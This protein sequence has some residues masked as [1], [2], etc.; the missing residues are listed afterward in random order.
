ALVQK[1]KRKQ[2]HCSLHL[3]FKRTSILHT[4]FFHRT[5][6][7]VRPKDVD[8]DLFE[9][10]YVQC[11]LAELEKEVDEKINQFIAWAEKH[12][13]RKSQVCLSFFDEKNKHPGW[14][15]SKTERVYWEQW[16]I[17]LH[18]TSPKGQGKSRGSKAPAN[19]KGQ[20]LEE[21]SSRR[22][23]LSLLIQ[24]VLFQIINYANEKK[25]HIPPIS[26]RIFNHEILVPR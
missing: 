11:G 14:F 9:I 5:L 20:A 25:D 7:L 16:F 26:D 18:V 12:P 23:A 24:E 19:T 4:I 3:V 10:T 17:N 15:S 13:N 1:E 22:D 21:T 2:L 8:C 6:T